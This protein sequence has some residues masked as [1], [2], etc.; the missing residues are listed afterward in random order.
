M[1]R[2]METTAA[3]TIATTTAQTYMEIIAQN[4]KKFYSKTAAQKTNLRTD[5]GIRTKIQLFFIRIN[6]A[7]ATVC[8]V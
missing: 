4:A 8:H 5:I 7:T 3:A 1:C 6:T 2:H